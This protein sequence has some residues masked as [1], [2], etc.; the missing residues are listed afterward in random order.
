MISLSLIHIFHSSYSLISI[1]LSVVQYTFST[2]SAP[3]SCNR[4]TLIRMSN[5]SSDSETKDFGNMSTNRSAG[6]LGYI[7]NK[8][9]ILFLCI[10]FGASCFCST[11]TASTR[12]VE[13]Q[14]AHPSTTALAA[15]PGKS[16]VQAVHSCVQ[17][18]PST[19]ASVIWVNCVCL[20]PCTLGRSHL[21]EPSC[22]C[23]DLLVPSTSEQKQLVRMD[24]SHLVHP[25][26]TE[27]P[28]DMKP[29]EHSLWTVSMEKRQNFSFCVK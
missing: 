23:R 4:Y 16:A 24:F 26:G 17:V 1:Y 5:I 2:F 8:C 18:P 10:L 13:C 21:E 29:M 11:C 7:L 20:F 9:H 28:T 12:L 3:S 25:H 27:L 22:H 6:I 15:I 19:G 14:C